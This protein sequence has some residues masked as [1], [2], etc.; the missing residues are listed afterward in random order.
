MM[1]F[2][3]MTN[4]LIQQTIFNA[5]KSVDSFFMIGGMFL[6]FGFL[7]QMEKTKRFNVLMYCLHR[8]L[9]YLYIFFVNIK[10]IR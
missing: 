7:N 9:R 8:F 5:D 1:F 3:Q 4:K 2:F 10:I 6:T